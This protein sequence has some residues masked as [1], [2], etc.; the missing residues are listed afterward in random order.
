MKSIRRQTPKRRQVGD[1]MIGRII[2]LLFV[3]AL[4]GLIGLL[5]YAYSGLMQPQTREITRPV[6]LDVN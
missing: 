3:L 2:K 6:E 4:L 5:G 1:H